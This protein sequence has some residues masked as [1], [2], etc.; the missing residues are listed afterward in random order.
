MKDSPM[1]RTLTEGRTTMSNSDGE[2]WKRIEPLI[3]EDLQRDGIELIPRNLSAI[4]AKLHTGEGVDGKG[5]FLC[6][7]TG[8]GKTRRL[9][10]AANAFGIEMIGA[11]EICNRLARAG[12]EIEENEVL[13]LNPA[14][15][16]EV[17]EHYNDLIID[18]I[19]TEPA[20]F[21]VYGTKRNLMADII[22]RRYKAF[23]DRGR[24]WKTHFT[25]NLTPE[26]IRVRYG[27]RVWS[28]LNEMVV[29]ITL[30]GKDRRMK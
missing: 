29:F 26:E 27:E 23:S 15:W 30:A 25:S 16:S 4:L 8:T 21:N 2:K 18:D 13:K 9:K 5:L 11:Q 7:N 20:E 28:R 1:I 19:G 6:G 10:W 22:Y 24:R 17:P 12:D 14:P 3:R